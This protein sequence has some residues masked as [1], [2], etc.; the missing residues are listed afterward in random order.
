MAD[1]LIEGTVRVGQDGSNRTGIVWRSPT[2]GYQF[3]V[4]GVTNTDDWVY[5]KT[6]DG[7]STWGAQVLVLAGDFNHRFDLWADWWT[8]GDTGTVV[9]L[10]INQNDNLKYIAFDTNGDVVGSAVTIVSPGSFSVSDWSRSVSITKSR[11]GLLYAHEFFTTNQ[12]YVSSDGTSWTSKTGSTD[13]DS[14]Y[15]YLY[16]GNMADADDVFLVDHHPGVR[17]G[18]LHYDAS[19][20]TWSTRVEIQATNLHTNQ[21]YQHMSAS[22]RHSDATLF[23]AGFNDYDTATA[24]LKFFSMNMDSAAPTVTTLTDILSNTSE[25]TSPAVQINQI[26]GLIR[27]YYLRGGT[28]ESTATAYY[29]ESSDG[30]S[31]WDTETA[32]STDAA[33]DIR[34]IYVDPSVGGNSVGGR[35]QA[36]WRIGTAD[37]LYTVGGTDVSAI[38]AALTGTVTSS[39]TEADI[40][41]GGKT[42]IITL[43]GTT[44]NED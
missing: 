10:L 39:I 34:Q 2:V 21:A 41:A 16:P 9:H 22:V 3:Y 36:S 8:E 7:G 31:T 13:D 38:S 43:T 33:A 25:A 29:K 14:G 20:N 4:A 26:S 5:R 1:V 28:W 24:D 40:V 44:W 32:F 23:F 18:I 30:G 35:L 42:I 6:S 15:G 11:S 17:M 27:V 37:D 19:G 12:F